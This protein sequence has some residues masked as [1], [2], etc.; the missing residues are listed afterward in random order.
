MVMCHL[1]VL[2][3]SWHVFNVPRVVMAASS[4]RS[5]WK[6]TR[7]D[8]F[9]LVE[10]LVVVAIIAIL[11]A[12]LLPAVQVAREAARRAECSNNLRNMGLAVHNYLSA[13]GVFPPASTEKLPRHS[14][15]TRILPYFE[16]DRTFEQV[17]LALNWNH[18]DNAPYTKQNLGGILICR[19]APSGREDDHVTDYT[20]ALRVET[21]N[22][23]AG[24]VGQLAAN[25]TIVNRGPPEDE[26]WQGLMQPA[27]GIFG[28]LIK[29]AR[30]RDG[31]SNTILF[32]EV[33]GRPIV[34]EGG[35]ATDRRTSTHRWA[36]WQ[37]TIE[38]DRYCG[39]SQMINCTNSDEIYG[40]HTNGCNV[41]HGDGS[42][43][44]L[45]ETI[46]AESFVAMITALAGD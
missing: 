21:G 10:L 1:R 26:S 16:Q 32:V 43:H 18:A 45:S 19:S 11:I 20:V 4:C 9:T 23:S 35:Q 6:M 25:G 39:N 14:F 15:V 33:A 36:N 30:V 28:Q 29:P 37:V 41:A 31:L 7:H 42:V 24:R 13:F 27:D 34:H 38:I 8:G 17:D 46:N 22:N 3:R 44:F 40:F 12:M 5:F 2:T